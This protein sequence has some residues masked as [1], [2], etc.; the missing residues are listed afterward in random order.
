MSES[1]YW[2]REIAARG[3]N[4]RAFLRSAALTGVGAA[5]FLAGCGGS[6]KKTSTP[7][8][9]GAATGAGTAAPAAGVF[10]VPEAKKGGTITNVGLDP[11]TGWDP[12]GTIAYL[13]GYITEPMQIKLIRHDYRGGK[14]PWKSGADDAIIGEL[15][16]KWENPDPLTYNFT[17]RKGINWPSQEPMNGRPITAADVKYNFD[18]AKL[19]TSL[20]QEYVFNNIKSVTAVDDYTVQFKTNYPHWRWLMDLDSYNTGIIPKGVYEWTGP[21]G[22]K[23]PQKARGGGPWLLDSYAPGSVVRWKPNEAYRKVFGVPYA[24][25]LDV[26]ILANGAPRLQAFVGK[27]V[28]FFDA[29]AGQLDAAQKGRPD[30]KSLLDAFAP[31]NTNAVFMKTTEKPWD[32]VRLRRALSMAI[33]RDGWG[34]TLQYQYKWESGPI[35]WGYPAQKLAHDKMP[36]ETAKWLKYDPAEAKKLVDAAGVSASTAFTMHMYP[37]NDTYTPESQLLIDSFSKIGVTAKLKVYEYNNWLATAYVGQYSGLLYGPDNL[38][39]VT[40]QVAD[41]LL[42]NSS[43]NH[44]AIKDEV[45]QKLLADFAAAKGPADGKAVL[46]QIQI[47]SVDQAFAVYRPQPVTPK[48]WDPALQNYDGQAAIYYQNYYRDAF[49]WL[50]P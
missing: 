38:D 50:T 4:R 6:S 32:D 33:D 49:E 31:T 16:E 7:A 35:T 29:L 15:A 20:V 27:K 2:Q 14:N 28:Q 17:L 24:D 48:L 26:A 25:R 12:H 1:S 40:Q 21:D 22:M 41:R 19:P 13:T 30:A 9:G 46:D 23:D 42:S 39:R 44:S 18:H 37:Y 10:A 43:R 8:A 36:A 5:A 47:R 3:L 11:T 45:A 34:K